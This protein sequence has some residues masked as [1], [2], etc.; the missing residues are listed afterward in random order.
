MASTAIKRL[1]A[2][3][4]SPLLFIRPTTAHSTAWSISASSKMIKASLPP[5][6]NTDFFK[7][8]PA[9]A[10]MLAPAASLP[11]SETPLILSS[12]TRA[13]ARLPEISKLV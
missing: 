10:A 2:T 4:H 5:N 6:S 7:N 12:A 3:Q 11:V 8:F 1:A 13:E 9:A